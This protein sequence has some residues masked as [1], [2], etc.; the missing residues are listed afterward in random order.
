M[1]TR[2][3]RFARGWLAA[4]IAT[5][6]AA[7]FH[8]A[9]GGNPPGLLAITLSLAFSGIACVALA[10]KRLSLWRLSLSVAL[11]QFLFHAL[12]SLGSTGSAVTISGTT[13]H[14]HH[15][16][17]L[18][19]TPLAGSGAHLHTLVQTDPW[20]W[21]GHATAALVTVLALRFGERA[22]WGLYETARI[23][24]SRVVPTLTLVPIDRMP[25]T[26]TTS[27]A[28]RVVVLRDLGIP[29]GRMRHRGPPLPLTFA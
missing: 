3:A 18:V 27:V 23:R 5:F 1:S 12:F 20:M 26:P 7:F 10:G 28:A 25:G 22:F 15:A 8:A 2:W 9:T 13:D 14:A 21:V 4:G 16:T 17:H 19:V 6:V 24:I 29:L 11:S